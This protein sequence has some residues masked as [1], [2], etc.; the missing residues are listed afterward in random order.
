MLGVVPIRRKTPGTVLGWTGWNLLLLTPFVIAY[1]VLTEKNHGSNRNCYGIP[2][3]VANFARWAFLGF[4]IY[5]LVSIPLNIMAIKR[6]RKLGR[7][8][9]FTHWMQMFDT[10]HWLANWALFFHL[11]TGLAN[12][13]QCHDHEM[14]SLLWATVFISAAFALV[15]LVIFL[16]SLFKF[17]S[18]LLKEIKEE[19]K[20]RTGASGTATGGAVEV[21]DVR[22]SNAVASERVVDK[23]AAGVISNTGVPTG[24]Y[25]EEKRDEVINIREDARH[26]VRGDVRNEGR[27]VRSGRRQIQDIENVE[28]NESTNVNANNVRSHDVRAGHKY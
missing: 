6:N 4:A 20:L 12:R 19:A 11:V 9:R 3:D 10:L 7:E 14:K 25:K 22:K 24:K 27:D 8:S 18:R 23:G 17:I 16:V 15:G 26:E 1:W 21:V 13:P 5:Q 2:W 28:N